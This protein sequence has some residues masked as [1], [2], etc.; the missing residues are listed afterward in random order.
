M[1]QILV[2][3]LI[4]FCPSIMFSVAPVAKLFT[5]YS[6]CIH[7]LWMTTS[8]CST[9][10]SSAQTAEESAVVPDRPPDTMS[11]CSLCYPRFVGER[12]GINAAERT[13]ALW[14][15]ASAQVLWDDVS[16]GGQLWCE[17]S[18]F[19]PLILRAK[20]ENLCSLLTVCTSVRKRKKCF[21]AEA[22]SFRAKGWNKKLLFI[23]ILLC[24]M[25][26]CCR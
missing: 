11:I 20:C 23:V 9:C 12:W 14:R 1:P 18:L 13:R 24:T 2:S 15:N 16:D 10:V 5:T 7:T 22:G 8:Y 6:K 25:S 21:S 19:E 26:I 4:L 17:D 3:D